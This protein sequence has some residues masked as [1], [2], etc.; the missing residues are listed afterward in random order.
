MKQDAAMAY[1]HQP[2]VII[3]GASG[4]IGRHLVDR[5]KDS[6]RIYAFARRS[7]RESGIPIHSNIRWV[8]SDIADR[9][10]MARAVADIAKDNRIDFVVHLAAYY[11]F[12]YGPH[13]EYYRTNVLGT[14]LLLSLSAELG[15]K[16]FILAS[17][18]GGCNFPPAGQT[19]NESSPLDAAFPYAATKRRCEEM[20]K[21]YSSRIPSASMRFA[22]IYSDWCEYPPL[23]ML[24]KRWLSSSWLSRMIPGKGETALPYI[25]IQCVMDAILLAMENAHR[26]PRYDTYVVSPDT[27]TSFRELYTRGVRLH[28]GNPKR[29]VYVPK[30]LSVAGIH[31]QHG[32]RRLTGKRSLEQPW[33]G[34]Y[35]DLKLTADC[36]Y[37][38]QALGWE[39]RTELDILQR[40]AVMIGNLRRHP[41][42]WHRANLAAMAKT[43]Q[44][45]A[46]LA[47]RYGTAGCPFLRCRK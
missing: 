19:I 31:A 46:D 30:A 16:R 32:W 8:R 44:E 47:C 38:R 37:T 7:Q 23:Y 5:L 28:A 6:C 20:L 24:L 41:V 26:L 42:K 9:R 21:T 40:L 17:S 11:D 43:D 12:N 3:T 15:I 25:H 35:I 13:P 14:G 34:K 18:L 36:R 22:A 27:A 33:M 2:G 1:P 45:K 29:P 4:F 10:R 39:P